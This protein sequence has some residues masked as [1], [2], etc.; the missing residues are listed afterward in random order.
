MVG[1]TRE[2]SLLSRERA[3]EAFASIGTPEFEEKNAR[4]AEYSLAHIAER[5]QHPR[6]DF[7]TVLAGGMYKGVT[8]DDGTAVQILTA[9]LMGGHHSTSSGIS[10][11]LRYVLTED[12]VRAALD[13]EPRMLSRIIEESLRLTTPLQ[14]FARTAAVSTAL[15]QCPVPQGT[16]LLINY[17]AANRDPQQ[18]SDPDKFDLSRQ[19]IPHLAFGAGAHLCGGLHLARLEIKTAL[20]RLLN[21]FPDLHVSGEIT[22][23]GLIA[24]VL[25]S[26]TALPVAFTPE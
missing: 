12:G 2:E 19:R 21:R 17:A 20:T 6:N 15:G 22:D 1:L 14:M 10:G 5:R 3:N 18:F 25:M 8:I 11:T 26:I 7:L 9:L 23:A 13:D 4:F 16:R 24:G